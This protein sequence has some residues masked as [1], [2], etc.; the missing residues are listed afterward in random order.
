MANFPES[1]KWIPRCVGF[2]VNRILRLA[3]GLEALGKWVRSNR[4]EE[5]LVCDNC[6]MPVPK[7]VINVNLNKK[8]SS[9]LR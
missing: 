8:A 4:L 3:V 7:A 9:K 2:S 6:F 5:S 1:A